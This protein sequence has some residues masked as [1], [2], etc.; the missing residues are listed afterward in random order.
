[1]ST[2]RS[3]LVPDAPIVPS[4]RKPFDDVARQEADARALASQLFLAECLIAGTAAAWVKLDVTSVA[5]VK[6]DVLVRTSANSALTVTRA[7]ASPLAAAGIP[8]GI[9]VR[10]A[11]PGANVLVAFDGVVGPDVTGLAASSPG[12]VRVAAFRAAQVS[13]LVGGDFPLG[14][15]DAAGWLTFARGL[16]VGS[17]AAG[18]AG[19]PGGDGSPVTIVGGAPGDASHKSG[20][21]QVQL[22]TPGTTDGHTGQFAVLAGSVGTALTVEYDDGSVSGLQGVKI[23]VPSAFTQLNGDLAVTGGLAVGGGLNVGGALATAAPVASPSGATYTASSAAGNTLTISVSGGIAISV[24]VASTGIQFE[25]FIIQDSA[26]SHAV[27]WNAAVKFA[28]GVSNAASLTANGK[29]WFQIRFLGGVAY[30]VA[31]AVLS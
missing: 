20:A 10:A 17:P 7:D 28:T 1:M 16:A 22:G 5:V 31:R 4:A 30:V 13:A 25:I 15:V 29:T 11:A 3:T 23:D 18:T 8:Y 24:N 2:F 26:G 14:Y 21:V 12:P 19:N 9:A 27:T 6:G